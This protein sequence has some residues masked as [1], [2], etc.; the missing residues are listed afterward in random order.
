MWVNDRVIRFEIASSPSTDI[1]LARNLSI[2]SDVDVV[3]KPAFLMAGTTS[4]KL[5]CHVFSKPFRVV[6]VL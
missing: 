6:F 3:K 4:E 5:F 1:P 2:S